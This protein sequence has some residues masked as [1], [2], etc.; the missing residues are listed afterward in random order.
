MTLPPHEFIRRFLIH[1]LPK[2]FHRIRHYGLLASA[3]RAAN[4]ARAR[5]LL[6]V[7][8]TPKQPDT[9][10]TSAAD[11]PRVLPRPCPCCGDR[12]IIIETFAR[13][14]EPKHR[15]A[16]APATIRIDTS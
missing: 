15:P 4:I 13:G 2:G 10:E 1:V 5:E 16:P 14:C 8:A 11:E 7:P 6:A 3:N 12:M 9:P